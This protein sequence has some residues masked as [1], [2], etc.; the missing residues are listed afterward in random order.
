MEIRASYTTLRECLDEQLSQ[1]CK[2][3]SNNQRL[4]GEIEKAA[5]AILRGAR[6]FCEAVDLRLIDL[7]F[8]VR[9]LVP[10]SREFFPEMETCAKPIRKGYRAGKSTAEALCR[11]LYSLCIVMC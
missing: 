6:F 8:K 3:Y 2:D 1:T 4:K 5:M 10:C 7:D 9:S 11:Y